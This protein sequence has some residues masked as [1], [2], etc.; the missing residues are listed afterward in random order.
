MAYIVGLTTTDGCLCSGRR[1][2]NFKS[3]DRELV[4]TYLSLLGRTNRVH[5][6]MTRARRIVYFTEFHDTRLYEWFLSI[7]L[8][9]RKSLT[10]GAL[11]VPDRWFGHFLRGHLDGDGSVL[12][13]TYQGTGKA[14]GHSYRTLNVRFISGS[15]THVEWLRDRV[16]DLYGIAGPIGWSSVHNVNYAKRSSLRLLPIL[17]PSVDVPCLARKREIWATFVREVVSEHS[18]A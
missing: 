12:D 13:Y 6:A 15:K 4:A 7:G 18:I 14:A 16:R 5:E 10:I 8:T 3:S 2:V 1:R 9:P 17:Y 11:D